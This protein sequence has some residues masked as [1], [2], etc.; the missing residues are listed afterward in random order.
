LE[1]DF[2]LRLKPAS[3]LGSEITRKTISKYNCMDAAENLDEIMR[4]SGSA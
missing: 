3:S 1:Q 2:A 4:L